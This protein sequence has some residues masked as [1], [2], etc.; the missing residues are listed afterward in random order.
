MNQKNE[1]DTL[2]SP[3][4]RGST[5]TSAIPTGGVSSNFLL[6]EGTTSK[7]ELGTIIDFDKVLRPVII[8]FQLSC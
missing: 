2:L 5:G 3:G 8:R 6:L 4:S 7:R 1:Y